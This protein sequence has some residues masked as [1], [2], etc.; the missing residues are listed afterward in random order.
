VS[1]DAV[2]EFIRALDQDDELRNRCEEVLGADGPDGVVKLA[3]E[4]GWRF[5]AD[6][7]GASGAINAELDDE[8]L[9]K[10]AGGTFTARRLTLS[11]R[12]FRGVSVPGISRLRN[13]AG[14]GG[15]ETPDEEP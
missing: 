5:T 12:V 7:L 9:D 13:V 14:A 10:V 4:R 3:A 15:D 8:D 11:P 6:E 1:A 2:T